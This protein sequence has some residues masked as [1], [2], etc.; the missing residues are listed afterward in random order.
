ME[1]GGIIGGEGRG[2]TS[3]LIWIWIM[4]GCD[5]A[6]LGVLAGTLYFEWLVLVRVSVWRDGLVVKRS[7]DRQPSKGIRGYCSPLGIAVVL[8]SVSYAVAI[9][10]VVRW[11]VEE[12][13]WKLGTW[14]YD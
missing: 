11:L 14:G 9:R 13:E 7:I 5:C 6:L 3:L 10:S 4:E 1:R 12:K 2:R 8:T